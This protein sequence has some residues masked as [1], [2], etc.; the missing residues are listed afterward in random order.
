MKNIIN[1][2][3]RFIEE[4]RSSHSR[5]DEVIFIAIGFVLSIIVLIVF[6]TSVSFLGSRIDTA[7]DVE[8]SSEVNTTFKLDLLEDLGI[9]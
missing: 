9:K 1:K 6:I 7:L 3:K 8:E 2:I 5:R 4:V